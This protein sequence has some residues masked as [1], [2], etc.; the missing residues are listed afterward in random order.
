MIVPLLFEILVVGLLGYAVVRFARGRA[1]G[2]RSGVG[3]R[4]LFEYALLLALVV[5]AGVGVTGLVE[6]VLAGDGD[7]VR[8]DE[9]ALATWLAFVLVGVPALAWLAHRVHRRLTADPQ[10]RSSF[11]W[12][13]YL[14]V[15]Q[16]GALLTAMFALARTLRWALGE[17][18]YDAAALA[19]ALV[20]SL[21][22][23]GHVVAARRLGAAE[24]LELSDLFGSAAGL[25][26]AASAAGYGLG[27]LLAAGYDEAFRVVVA[28]G[29]GDELRVA[30]AWL[31]VAIPVWWWHWASRA[32]HAEPT[33]LWRG[34]VLLLGVLGGVLTAL[35]ALGAVSF[36]AA[37]WLVGD[38]G[39]ASA[40][41]H[42]APVAASLAAAAVGGAVWAYHR[43]VL[44]PLRRDRSEVDRVYNYLLAAV[45]LGAAAGGVATLLAA[46]IDAALPASR[47]VVDTSAGDVVAVAVTLLAIGLP[48]WG[49]QWMAAQRH[50]AADP[51][52]ERGS[53]TRRA[54]L[55]TTV[56]VGAVAAL[57]SLL[58][59]LIVAL[60]DVLEGT[61]A[62]DTVR[63]VEVALAILATAGAVVGWHVRELKADRELA[64]PPARPAVHDILLVAG[65]G[66][67]LAAALADEVG[68]PV[69]TWRRLDANGAAVPV[70]ELVAAVRSSPHEHLLVLTTPTGAYELVPIEPQR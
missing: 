13:A 15:A 64:P 53:P 34:Y 31:V 32:R 28:T 60:E 58:V 18:S 50:A 56:G 29:P 43:A 42:F 49:R 14:T 40:A 25:V 63:D 1:G 26:A 16:A 44:A 36:L 55:L 24:R 51:A 39:T 37:Q 35:G 47:V 17:T 68:V 41:D 61:L 5:I 10:E 8:R 4:R 66:A 22:W 27:A 69:R 48:V 7:L 19:T 30:A 21:V 45:G 67:G 46:A 33:S 38:P 70:A 2:D 65:D 11:A 20:W 6:E 54:Y 52:G 12:A 59:V 3:L 57:V 62:A 9:S 23:V